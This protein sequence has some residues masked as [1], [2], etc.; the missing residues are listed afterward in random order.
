MNPAEKLRIAPE[1]R[2]RLLRYGFWFLAASLLFNLILGDMGVVEGIRQRAFARQ[3]RSEVAA[4]Q[5]TN[6]A[7][8]ADIRAL[9]NDPFRVE[10]IA[11][12]QMGLARPGEIIFLFTPAAGASSATPDTPPAAPAS[13]QATKR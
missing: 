12:E 7:M 1:N 4:L 8:A 9:H 13:N 3:L 5:A 6:D 2:A 10:S 11:R